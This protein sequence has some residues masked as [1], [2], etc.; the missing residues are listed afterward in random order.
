MCGAVLEAALATRLPDKLL[1]TA[2][3]KPVYRHTG[4]FSF[5]QRIH[6]EERHPVLSAELRKQLRN[7]ANWRNDAVHVQPDV[8]PDPALVLL[9]TAQLLGAILP[10]AS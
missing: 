4:V 9:M 5:G 3:W 6:Y 2:G 10:A 1:A 7:I 8:G